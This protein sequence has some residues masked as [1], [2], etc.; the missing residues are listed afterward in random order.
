MALTIHFDLSVPSNEKS[1]DRVLQILL[2]TLVNLNREYLKQNP[3]TPSIYDSG[4]RFIR[5]EPNRWPQGVTWKSGE[6]YEQWPDIGRIIAQGGGDCEDLA[7]W[8]AAELLESGIPARPAW[9]HREVEMTEGANV[10]K[11]M[12][13]Y[14]IIVWTPNGFED[15]SRKLGMGGP[16]DR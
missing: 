5:E 10:G 11:K 1:K 6:I 16:S 9:R 14:H 12:T 13:L 4:V 15:P 7:C 8:R 2:W 3:A